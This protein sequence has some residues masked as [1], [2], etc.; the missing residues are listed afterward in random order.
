MII[1]GAQWD[2]L[3]SRYGECGPGG[4]ASQVLE[5]GSS[6][7]WWQGG[8]NLVGVQEEE[9]RPLGVPPCKRLT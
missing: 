1:I 2:V 3:W 9:A 4:R 8:K 5:A 6:V 7:W